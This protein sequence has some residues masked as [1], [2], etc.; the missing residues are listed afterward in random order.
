VGEMR[1][2]LATNAPRILILATSSCG[3]P[4][5]DATG[6][7]HLS[8]PANTYIINV[9][10]PAVFPE[11]FYYD[12]FEK[13]IGGIIVMSCGVECPYEGAY[14]RLAARLDRVSL[15]LKQRGID[16]GR[17]KLCAVCTVCTKAFL[18]EVHQMNELLNSQSVAAS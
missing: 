7:A 1:E 18:R 8:Y 9:P 6:Q 3:Y 2:D 14:E 12:C 4:G 13:G 17:L 11:Q 10:S 15:G 5:A 16:Q